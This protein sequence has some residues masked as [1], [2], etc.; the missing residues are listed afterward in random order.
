MLSNCF[1]CFALG[2]VAELLG[3]E[4]GPL[5]ADG[6][7]VELHLQKDFL[8]DDGGQE[9]VEGLLGAA[10]GVARQ[11]RQGVDH[12]PGEGRGEAGFEAGLV[13][14]ALG[15]D[16]EGDAAGVVV[17]A[18]GPGEGLGFEHAV[19]V[20][21]EGHLH[22]VRLFVGEGLHA[23]DGLAFAGDFDAPV[24]S[25]LAVGFQFERLRRIAERFE[26]ASFEFE[27]SLDRLRRSEI[28]MDVRREDDFVGFD[29]EPRSLQ[30]KEQVLLRGDHGGGF[31]DAAAAAEGPGPDFPAGEVLRH[32]EENFGETFGVRGD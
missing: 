7:E 16:G 29:E 11:V 26:S 15:G 27:D 30:A 31:A 6:F 28:V 25:L 1:H 3:V 21:R 12:R 20:D 4:V 14:P 22:G 19:D 10:I 9:A 2:G 17:G 24:D 5:V 32:F 13:G 23:D 18:E 8:G